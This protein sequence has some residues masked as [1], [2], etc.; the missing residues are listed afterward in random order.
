MTSKRQIFLHVFACFTFPKLE[1][2]K[3]SRNNNN[4]NT[5]SLVSCKTTFFLSRP[6]G[7]KIVGKSVVM[8]TFDSLV[9]NY[10]LPINHI[11]NNCFV[12]R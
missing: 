12:N 7:A 2:L 1:L 6:L 11:L 9:N 10:T 4:N 3:F 5:K 8:A